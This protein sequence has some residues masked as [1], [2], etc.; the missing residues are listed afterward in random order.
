MLTALAAAPW[1]ESNRTRLG[2]AAVA[3]AAVAEA[4]AADAAAVADAAEAVSASAAA[5][6]LTDATALRWHERAAAPGSQTLATIRRQ[7]TAPLPAARRP[8]YPESQ[9]LAR[10]SA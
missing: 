8:T 9:R 7:C 3:E 2:A 10:R 5:L 1:P 6:T 4:A